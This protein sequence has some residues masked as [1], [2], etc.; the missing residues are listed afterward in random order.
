MTGQLVSRRERKGKERIGVPARDGWQGAAAP[1]VVKPC[2][3]PVTALL[4]A[5]C[6]RASRAH[7]TSGPCSWAQH[8]G[9]RSARRSFS[10]ELPAQVMYGHKYN[11]IFSRAS[12]WNLHVPPGFRFWPS[13]LVCIPAQRDSP[14]CGPAWS[15]CQP[16]LSSSGIRVPG[17]RVFG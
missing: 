3:G 1:Q 16:G 15:H 7:T 14:S 6:D 17:R 4:G 2:T 11:P 9:V 8:T 12:V 5:G 10:S 13:F